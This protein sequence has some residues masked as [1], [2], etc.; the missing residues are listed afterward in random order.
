MVKKIEVS[1]L[2]TSVSSQSIFFLTASLQLLDS[3]RR[4]SIRKY[5]IHPLYKVK[6]CTKQLWSM[7]LIYRA[8]ARL[9]VAID[10]HSSKSTQKNLKNGPMINLYPFFRRVWSK[11][12]LIARLCLLFLFQI[13]PTNIL[14]SKMLRYVTLK[15]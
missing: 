6:F 9:K 14:F 10:E 8:V 5:M 11:H 7:T 2:R 15:T 12:V 1:V 3:G 13:C 4:K